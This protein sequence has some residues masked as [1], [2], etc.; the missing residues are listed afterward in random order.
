MSISLNLRRIIFEKKS[1]KKDLYNYLGISKQTLEDYLS[2]KTSMTVATL[3]K[4]ATYFNI[5]VSYFFDEKEQS[6]TNIKGSKNQVGNGNVIIE[7]Q[8]NEIEYLKKLLAEKER[9]IQ[10]FINKKT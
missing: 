8:A 7:T 2:E 5:P 4:I 10:L 6:G 9:T 3:E 1:K